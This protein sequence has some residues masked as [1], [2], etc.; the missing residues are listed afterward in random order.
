M[1]ITKDDLTALRN[2]VVDVIKAEQEILEEKIDRKIDAY[3][4]WETTPQ[5][6]GS[7]VNYCQFCGAFIGALKK[8]AEE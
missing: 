3:F 7:I 8:Q 5:I 4:E 6:R 1:K 2:V